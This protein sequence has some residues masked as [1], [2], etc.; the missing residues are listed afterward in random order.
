MKYAQYKLSNIKIEFS[1]REDVE[2]TK[3]EIYKV[4]LESINNYIR[5][6]EINK[7]QGERHELERINMQRNRSIREN[8][9]SDVWKGDERRNKREKSRS[10]SFSN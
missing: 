8:K 2:V 3:E 7:E 6:K 9:E 5:S 1:L 10:S 4:I